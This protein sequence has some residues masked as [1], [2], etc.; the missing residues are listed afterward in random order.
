MMMITFDTVSS[1]LP[2]LE[3]EGPGMEDRVARGF[4]VFMIASERVGLVGGCV[5]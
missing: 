1:F 5:V 2:A 3:E 4:L